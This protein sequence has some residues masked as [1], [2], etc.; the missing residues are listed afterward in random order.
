MP[1]LP[2]NAGPKKTA[3]HHTAMAS[4][5]LVHR[6]RWIGVGGMVGIIKAAE[7]VLTDGLGTCGLQ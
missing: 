7:W 4:Q 2:S 1:Q 6:W 3:T 5:P